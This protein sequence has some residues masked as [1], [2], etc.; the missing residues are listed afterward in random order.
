MLRRNGRGQARADAAL[1]QQLELAV[2]FCQLSGAVSS[3]ERGYFVRPD[4]ADRWQLL[5]LRVCLWHLEGGIGPGSDSDG[6]LCV[7]TVLAMH[8]RDEAA[9]TQRQLESAERD[10]A[11][12]TAAHAT[13]RAQWQVRLSLS[14]SLSPISVVRSESWLPAGFLC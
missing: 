12:A 7:V 8:Q 9:T 6:R 2:R 11:S 10:A 13:Q 4:A 1:E 14:G 3:V 5:R